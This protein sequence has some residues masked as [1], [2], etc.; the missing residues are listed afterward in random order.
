[1]RD[2][3]GVQ[4]ALDA[5]G[6]VQNITLTQLARNRRVLFIEGLYDFSILRKLARRVGLIELSMGTG[7]TPIESG[8]FSSWERIQILATG[9][10]KTLGGSLL[11]G[12]IFDRDY[13]SSEEI[14]KI[15]KELNEHLDFAH[16]H[17]RKEI[18]NYLLIPEVLA[19][20]IKK[21]ILESSKRNGGKIIEAESVYLILEKL[22]KE[23]RASVQAQYI[24]KRMEFFKRSNKDKATI[25]TETI[26]MFDSKWENLASRMEIIPGKDVLR[27]LR[28]EL[29]EKY[30]ITLTDSRIIEEFKKE[31][32]PDD[33]VG[34]LEK[35]D[36]Y[37]VKKYAKNSTLLS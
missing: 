34:L 6:S 29:Q 15:N 25:A 11:I 5:I 2:I 13:C 36:E 26:K 8:G 22:T 21:A 1:M 27:E 4:A 10:E 31:E 37:R 30:N 7:L 18:E 12:A 35:I 32:I 9:I 14:E 24:S 19:R 33:L 17:K 28:K 3:E 20:A 16:F 23:L